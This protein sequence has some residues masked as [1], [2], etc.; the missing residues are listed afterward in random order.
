MIDWVVEVNFGAVARPQFALREEEQVN[1]DRAERD[2]R[3]QNTGVRFKKAY[4]VRKYGFE[5][6]EIDVPEK[7][8][9]TDANSRTMPINEGNPSQIKDSNG[10]GASEFEQTG[11]V[12]AIVQ[13]FETALSHREF[14]DQTAVDAAGEGGGES[15]QQAVEAMLAPALAMIRQGADY[16]TVAARLREINPA[17]DLGPLTE[18]LRRAFFAAEIWGRLHADR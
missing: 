10:S 4:F 8:H 2:E 16:E 5:E 9:V 17:M 11:F 15:L 18:T 14:P 13:A 7:T 3:I 12:N 6:D 1:K